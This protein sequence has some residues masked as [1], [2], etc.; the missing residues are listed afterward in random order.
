[1]DWTGSG[2]VILGLALLTAT[3]TG[4]S[5]LS[6][7]LL[8]GLSERLVG[9]RV[10]FIGP[11]KAVTAT[12]VVGFILRGIGRAL[13]NAV[14][15][16]VG[17]ALMLLGMIYFLAWYLDRNVPR[18]DGTPLGRDGAYR[19]AGVHAVFVVVVWVLAYALTG[20]YR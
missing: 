15:F 13:N 10:P 12:I 6:A 16:G 8:V 5:A 18:P 11:F 14:G 1:M 19:L 9:F 4:L 20:A 3:V 2:R 17:S 7:G